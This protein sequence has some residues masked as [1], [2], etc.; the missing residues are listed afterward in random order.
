LWKKSYVSPNLHEV[1][2]EKRNPN[3]AFVNL[4]HLKI[5]IPS[6]VPGLL[7]YFVFPEGDERGSGGKISYRV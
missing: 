6:L 4:G 5:F 7:L 2:L 1:S 3:N